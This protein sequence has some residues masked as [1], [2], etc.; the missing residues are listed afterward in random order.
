MLKDKA[1]ENLAAGDLL[2]ERGHPNAAASRYYYAMFQA[3]VH[4]LN[5][6]GWKPGAVRSGAVDWDHSM[7]LNNLGRIGGRWNE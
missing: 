2:V 4:R 3:A 7:V 6:K 1:V 5:L